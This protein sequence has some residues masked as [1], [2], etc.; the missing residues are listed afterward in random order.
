MKPEALSLESKIFDSLRQQ[1]DIALNQCIAKMRE[2]GMDEGS[3]SVKIGLVFIESE[4]DGHGG[5]RVDT[6]KIDG[7]VGMT[8]PIRYESKIGSQ[9]GIKC[10]HGVK[11]YM[12]ADG[13]ISMDEV[14]EGY[15]DDEL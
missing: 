13:Q 8:V 10:V 9:I 4:R 12:I 1:T 14:L 3:V 5:P 7:K 2:T 15:E 11:S 6:M